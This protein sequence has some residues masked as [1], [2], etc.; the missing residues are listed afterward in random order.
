MA[1]GSRHTAYGKTHKSAL[2][3]PFYGLHWFYWFNLFDG[4]KGSYNV[5][6]KW[7]RAMNLEQGL[8]CQDVVFL[9]IGLP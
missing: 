1:H 9:V 7:S 5:S 3:C 4:L 6:E 8:R 2:A